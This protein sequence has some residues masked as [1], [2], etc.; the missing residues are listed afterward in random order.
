MN[1]RENACGRGS[2]HM[3]AGRRA[4]I[5]QAKRQRAPPCAMLHET[6][7]PPR[8]SAAADKVSSGNPPAL[9]KP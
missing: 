5:I 6:S 3:L 1:R 7:Q 2:H 4:K 8:T 9:Y